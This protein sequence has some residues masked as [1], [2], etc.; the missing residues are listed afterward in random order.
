MSRPP[1]YDVS[2]DLLERPSSLDDY[3]AGDAS[4]VRGI[5]IRQHALM[6][7]WGTPAHVVTF[8]DIQ[9]TYSSLTTRTFLVRVPPYCKRM[10]VA[11]LSYG[12]LKFS[13]R[14]GTLIETTIFDSDSSEP[15]AATWDEGSTLEPSVG[16]S[17]GCMPV[18]A[19]VLDTWSTVVATVRF[20]SGLGQLLSLAF[21][22]VLEPAV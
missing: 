20:K 21:Y 14:V 13:L 17:T 22:P 2:L 1:Q 15:Q 11:A 7:G 18:L 6:C 10:R 8:D 9:R 16:N 19:V 3:T 5:E 12:S 4:L